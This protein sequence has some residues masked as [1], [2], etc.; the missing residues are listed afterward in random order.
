M[1]KP[2]RYIK[3]ESVISIK[4]SGLINVPAW[5]LQ[6]DNGAGDECLHH[7]GFEYRRPC[8]SSLEFK[9]VLSVIDLKKTE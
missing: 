8:M 6:S 2:L 1:K 9:V 5:V 7:A 4:V 3:V